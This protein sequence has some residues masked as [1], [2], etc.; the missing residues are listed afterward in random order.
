MPVA[1][2]IEYA[3][4]MEAGEAVAA[5]EGAAVELGTA[6]DA[7]LIESAELV[8]QTEQEKVSVGVTGDLQKSIGIEYDMKNRTAVVAPGESYALGVELGT[9]PHMP[10]VDALTPWAEM[11]GLNPWA[12]AMGIKKHGT[13][14]HPFV[15]PTV[16]ETRPVILSNAEIAVAKIIGG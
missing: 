9:G 7:W 16:E 2:S 8:K 11:H 13:A 15:Q 10:P 5:L 3:V 1:Y 12:V 4:T 14:P 6:L